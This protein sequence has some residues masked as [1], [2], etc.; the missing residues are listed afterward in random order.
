VLVY[1]FSNI[2]FRV[3]L[4]LH[5][6]NCF[7]GRA[8]RDGLISQCILF[9]N[10]Q[11][12]HK[13]LRLM[14]QEQSSGGFNYEVHKVHMDNLYRMSQYCDNH[15]DCRRSQILEY[16]GEIFDR[17]KCIENKQTLCDNCIAFTT[18][19]FT[20]KDITQDAI[21]IAKGIRE[22]NGLDVTL[23]HIGEILKGSMNVKIVEKQHNN[24]EMHGKLSRYKKTDIERVIRRLIFDGYLKEDVKILQHTDTV[25]SY[26][27]IGPKVNAL[28]NGQVKIQFDIRSSEK[29]SQNDDDDGEETEEGSGNNYAKSNKPRQSSAAGKT[30]K[31]TLNTT[32]KFTSKMGDLSAQNRILIRCRNDLKSLAKRICTEKCIQNVNS[33]FTTNMIKEMILNMPQTRDEILRITHFTEAIYLNYKGEDFLAVLKHYSKQLDDLRM[34]E[35][36]ENPKEKSKVTS[37]N[38][39]EANQLFDDENE[40]ENDWLTSKPNGSGLKRNATSFNSNSFK[41]P[42]NKKARNDADTSSYF[43]ESQSSNSSQSKFKNSGKKKFWK[44]K[45]NNNKNK[46]YKKK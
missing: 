19:A 33:I 14:K 45:K 20:L 23:L 34:V 39:S 21:C 44:F 26:I 29:E 27:K 9:Y 5:L 41:K 1:S 18:N 30:K 3:S 28:L 17:K 4:N 37:I 24:L 13:W 16:F 6:K 38:V 46:F 42:T 8:G 40:N 11:D 12:R 25:A 7:K 2:I 15:T 31:A 32:T 36:L 22:L 43:N 35:A 10:N